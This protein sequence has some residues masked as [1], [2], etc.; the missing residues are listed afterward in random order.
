[1][2]GSTCGPCLLVEWFMPYEYQEFP[3]WTRN[4]KQERLVHSR[5]ELEALGEGW[6]DEKHN[7]PKVHIDSEAFQHYPKWVG[8]KLVNSAEEEAALVPTL[9]QMCEAIANAHAE[10]ES[11]ERAMLIQIADEK[12]VR[13]DKRWSAE[14]IRAALEAV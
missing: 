9:E 10:P 5:E 7:P 14:K 12:G 3:K 11:D 6:S 2:F 8:D 4:G 13:I 1:M